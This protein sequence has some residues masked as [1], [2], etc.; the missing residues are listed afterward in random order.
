MNERKQFEPSHRGHNPDHA[1]VVT[2]EWH[3]IKMAFK[4]TENKV[5]PLTGNRT[6]KYILFEDS[7]HPHGLAFDPPLIDRAV[8]DNN[9]FA[10]HWEKLEY[11]FALPRFE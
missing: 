4:V 10:H 6:I 3:D 1:A 9:G 7:I 8:G 11:A 5:N 2:I